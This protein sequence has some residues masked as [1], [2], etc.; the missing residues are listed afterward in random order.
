MVSKI[1]KKVY[2][3]L[4]DVSNKECHILG[5]ASSN[6]GTIDEDLILLAYRFAPI[7]ELRKLI[8]RGKQIIDEKEI[9]NVDDNEFE[10][11]R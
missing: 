5:D 3:E 11:Y 10:G 2:E 9:D 7:K 4:S 1:R 6:V 8:V